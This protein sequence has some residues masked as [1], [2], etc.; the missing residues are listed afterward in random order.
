MLQINNQQIQHWGL[1]QLCPS[2]GPELSQTSIMFIR[3][4]QDT[5]HAKSSSY[6]NK[7]SM[8][9]IDGSTPI[10]VSID[11]PALKRRSVPNIGILYRDHIQ[12]AHEEV[13]C[14]GRVWS[15]H[16]VQQTVVTYHFHAD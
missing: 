9:V 14:E 3:L 4:L 15:P 5:C 13:G 16:R 6:T 7:H 11:N 2:I 12:V 10:Y 1:A 8:L